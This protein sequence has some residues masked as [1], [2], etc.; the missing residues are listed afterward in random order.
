MNLGESIIAPHRYNVRSFAFFAWWSD[1]RFLSDFLE[2]PSQKYF[3][4]GWHVRMR[5]YRRWGGISELRDAVVEKEL[6][7]PDGPVVAVT[8]AR[9]RI[10]ETIRFVKWG[11]PVESQVRQH[12]GKNLA[13]ASIRPLNTF[14]T[15]SIWQNEHQMLNMVRGRDKHD[16]QSHQLA[17][18]ERIRKD[19][20]HEFTTMRFVPFREDGIWNGKSNF[21]Q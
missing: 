6:A 20:H 14:S 18:R 2:Q 5:L 19:F 10:L 8:L 16:G 9:L 15:F 7:E 17:M 12:T 21:T 1:E 13:L 11:K 3:A 4:D